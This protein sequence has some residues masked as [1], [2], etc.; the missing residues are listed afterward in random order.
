MSVFNDEEIVSKAIESILNQTYQNLELLIMDDASTDLSF[1]RIN[2]FTDK[3]VKLYKNKTNLGLTKSLNKLISFSSGDFIARQD[4]DDESFPERLEVQLQ[5]MKKK[6][7]NACTTRALVKNSSRGIPL[8][9]YLLPSKL[10]M[11]YK[12]PFIHGTLLIQS[13]VLRKIGLYNEEYQYS[14]D[15]KLYRDLVNNNYTVKIMHKKLYTLNMENNISSHYKE[16]QEKYFKLAKK[17]N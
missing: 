2:N 9:S 5:Y 4:S 11:R 12:N 15:Y 8:F 10:V 14:Q 6:K 17:S 7:L 3:R 16:Q 1:K 13:E